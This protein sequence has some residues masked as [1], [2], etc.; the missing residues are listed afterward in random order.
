MAD[1]NSQNQPAKKHYM[2][3]LIPKRPTFPMD[4]TDSER[5]IM[6]RHLEYLKNK[7]AKGLVIVFGPVMEPKGTWG[8]GVLE[9]DSEEQIDEIMKADPSITENLNTYEYYPMRAVLP[10]DL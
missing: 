4:I 9:V 6:K 1:I 3:R 2:I 10:R 8:M 5:E 7:M